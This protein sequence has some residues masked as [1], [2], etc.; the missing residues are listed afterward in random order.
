LHES[1][2][3]LTEE[4][5]DLHRG[6]SASSIAEGGDPASRQLALVLAGV[7]RCVVMR[8]EG[9]VFSTR[10]GAFVVTVGGDLAVGYSS[11]AG[12]RRRVTARD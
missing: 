7:H 12:D 1:E 8:K 9:A 11:S 5:R 4:T 10:D 6:S 3:R 2:E